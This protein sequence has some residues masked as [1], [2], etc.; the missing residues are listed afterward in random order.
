MKKSSVIGLF[1]VC[2]ALAITLCSCVSMPKKVNADSTIVTGIFTIKADNYQ[3]INV[4]GSLK[5]HTAEITIR[6][7]MDGTLHSTLI[8]DDGMYWFVNLPAEHSFAVTQILLRDSEGG[9]VWVDNPK[10]ER[11]TPEKGK[12]VNL[13]NIDMFFDGSKNWVSWKLLDIQSVTYNFKKYAEKKESEW[14]DKK[15]VISLLFK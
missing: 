9:S 14:A 5:G 13:G 11:F 7:Q 4:N 12:I 15:V 8:M 3:G 6:D 1:T 10:F 2:M